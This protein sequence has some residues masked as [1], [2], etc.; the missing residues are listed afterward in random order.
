[1]MIA[2]P[3]ASAGPASVARN[4]PGLKICG[5]W[6]IRHCEWEIGAEKLTKIASGYSN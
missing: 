6:G 5:E 3:G 1:M 2:C 4:L